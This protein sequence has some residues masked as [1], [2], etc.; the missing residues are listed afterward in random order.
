MRQ[1]MTVMATY[2]D[3]S[4]RDVTQ[5]AFDTGNRRLHEQREQHRG[6]QHPAGTRNDQHQTEPHQRARAAPPGADNLVHARLRAL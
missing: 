1:Q 5:E 3:G 4:T 6:H 2:A